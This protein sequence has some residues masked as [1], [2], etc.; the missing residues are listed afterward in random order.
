MFLGFLALNRDNRVYSGLRCVSGDHAFG[1]LRTQAS[2]ASTG[3]RVD[4]PSFKAKSS[5]E[6]I[7]SY[8]RLRLRRYRLQ[9]SGML[10]RRSCW[11]ADE[12]DVSGS[13]QV[14]LGESEVCTPAPDLLA[15]TRDFSPGVLRKLYRRDFVRLPLSRRYTFGL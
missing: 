10:S 11:C 8:A 7:S 3:M 2:A 14:E 1:N 9:N 12:C 13:G 5:P 4:R 15:M 6:R